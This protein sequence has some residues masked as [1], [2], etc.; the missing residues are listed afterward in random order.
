MMSVRRINTS[1]LLLTM[2]PIWEPRGAGGGRICA[3]GGIERARRRVAIAGRR[4]RVVGMDALL[5]HLGRR[6]APT[7]A[8][9]SVRAGERA[10]R[11]LAARRR[12]FGLGPA[13]VRI[14]LRR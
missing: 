11:R 7:A 5:E 2:M 6:V 4:R 10:R 1:M 9:R 13:F 3:G 12:S 14:P 8:R